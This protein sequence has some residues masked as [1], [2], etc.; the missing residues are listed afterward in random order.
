MA[1]KKNEPV[2]PVT[3]EEQVIIPEEPVVETPVEK[4]T[5]KKKPATVKGTVIGCL[6]LNVRE[7]MNLK[8]TPLS[9][10]PVSS[11]VKVVA[12]EEHDGWYHVFTSTGVEGYCMK[13]YISIKP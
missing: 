9:V 4:P 3:E 6:K 10:L 13:Q 12:N 2:A 11:E 5:A 7:Q 8:S 1:K